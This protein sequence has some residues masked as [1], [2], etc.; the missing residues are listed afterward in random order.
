MLSKH[1]LFVCLEYSDQPDMATLD[2][3]MAL[4]QGW[5]SVFVKPIEN[6]HYFCSSI[7]GRTIYQNH[8]LDPVILATS[9]D[10]VQHFRLSTKGKHYE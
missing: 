3:P 10:P 1:C 8:R 6:S 2:Q 7:Q 9:D 5:G 4:V